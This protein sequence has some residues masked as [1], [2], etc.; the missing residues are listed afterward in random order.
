[1]NKGKEMVVS[2]LH[3]IFKM[4]ERYKQNNLKTNIKKEIGDK[5]QEILRD[6]SGASFSEPT[7]LLF[8]CVAGEIRTE[9]EKKRKE[10]K[11]AGKQNI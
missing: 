11:S 1:M 8:R 3:T 10:R 6:A 9:Q 2:K 5:R 4:L 7:T